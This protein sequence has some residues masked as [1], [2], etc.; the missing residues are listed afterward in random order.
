MKIKFNIFE[1]VA[2]LFV[3]S[4]IIGCL[5]AVVFVAIK[6]GWLERRV[7]Y[8]SYFESAD[9]I[10]TGTPVQ[11]AGLRVGKV[12]EVELEG[13]EKVRVSF[14]VLEK[15]ATKIREDS[16]V[17]G[18]RPF[19]I[20]DKVLQISVGSKDRPQLQFGQELKSR[21]TTDVMDLLSGR[22]IGP[23][24]DTM[25]KLLVNVEILAEAFS[26]Q[27]RSEAFIKAFDQLEPL[28]KNLNK[29]SWEVTQLSQQLGYKGN[30]GQVFKHM[31]GVTKDLNELLP[32]FK[33]NSPELA[34]DLGRLMK[35]MAL[36][37]DELQVLLPVLTELAPELPRASKQA[38][39]ALDEAVVTLKAM[40]KSF[41]L[42]GATKKVK[43]ELAEE[44]REKEKLEAEKQAS[45]DEPGKKDELENSEDEERQPA[46]DGWF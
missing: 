7:V 41:F 33:E 2:G 39:K 21:A 1:R 28:M 35:N 11:M 13:A 23:A 37:T 24:L 9:G 17:I 26:Q 46:N 30:A 12:R 34:K 18:V 25:E 10:Y 6:Q 4:V 27:S 43:K 15:Y 38:I 32:A 8:Y 36:L 5:F 29:M 3:L 14:Q 22:K 20:S 16:R 19:I 44:A 45:E 40:Q 31:V 42:R